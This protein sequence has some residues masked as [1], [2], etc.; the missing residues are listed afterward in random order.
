MTWTQAGTTNLYVSSKASPLLSPVR[1][2][3]R[4]YDYRVCRSRLYI[5]YKRLVEHAWGTSV[6]G[7][8]A[9][10]RSARPYFF[11]FFWLSSRPEGTRLKMTTAGQ[12]NPTGLQLRG[13]GKGAQQQHVSPCPRSG[14]SQLL[15]A[16]LSAC[17]RARPWPSVT[18]RCSRFSKPT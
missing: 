15:A 7:I 3:H 13:G 9:T 8:H 14:P 18:I 1:S 5:Q 10:Y 12:E 2:T 6:Y 16:C 17:F 4:N 11:Y